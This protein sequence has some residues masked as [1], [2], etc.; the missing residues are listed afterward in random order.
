MSYPSTLSVHSL[1]HERSFR[2]AVQAIEL[3]VQK[4]LPSTTKGY[5]FVQVLTIRWENDDLDLY[6]NEQELANIFHSK[7]RYHTDSVLLPSSSSQHA[8]DAVKNK[9]QSIIDKHD[10]A[11]S[12]FIFAY[13]GHSS[14]PEGVG[15][16]GLTL[17]GSSSK[18]PT[19]S[20]AFVEAL[21]FPI[22]HADTLI[23]LDSCFSTAAA[24]G[25]SRHEYLAAAAMES[26]ATDV[27]EKSFTRRLIDLL[28]N[29][30][31]PVISV[32][33]VHARLVK[34]ANN[35]GSDLLHTPVHVASTMDKPSITLRPVA[36]IPR[37][38]ASLRKTSATLSDG[39]VLVTILLEGKTS[40][41]QVEEWKRWL[42]SRIPE[43]VAEIRLEAVFDESNSSLCLVTIPVAV[44]NML[45]GYEAYK[46]VAYVESHNILLD[47]ATSSD[48]LASYS[49]DVQQLPNTEK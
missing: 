39:K 42:S 5:D 46:F 13:E 47:T 4:A 19:L 43:D 41:P 32:S 33:Q 18:D 37:E 48:V 11:N 6:D 1:H 8:Y 26:Q 15:P 25:T 12:L 20:W 40:V 34:E 36:N 49:G 16:L 29:L 27:I 14:V 44:W 35:P 17:F 7:F 38:M 24:M 30:E 2:D 10:S 45:Q 3:G 28:Q 21:L 22:R 9:I 31:D 23:I